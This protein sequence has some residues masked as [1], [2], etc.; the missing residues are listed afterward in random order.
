[1]QLNRIKML[2]WGICSLI[3]CW[4]L[5]AKQDAL[6]IMGTTGSPSVTTDLTAAAKDIHDGLIQRGFAPDAVEILKAQTPDDKV[7][8]DRILESLKKRQT[9]AATD[10]FWVILLGFSGRSEEGAPAFQVSGPR[11]TAANLKTALDSIPAR[12]FVLVGTSDSGS[13]VPI[14]LT[15]NRSVLAAT[16]EEGEID[17]PRFPLSWAAALKENPRAGWKEIAARA[18]ELTE[19]EY[20]DNSLA[21][22]EHARLGDPESGAI[23]E[24]PFG[25]D[26]L[27]KPAVKPEP[28]GSMALIDASDIKVEI[29]KPN[30]E[31]EKQ[32]ATAETKKL[33]ETARATPNPEG[34]A[35]ILLEQRLGYRV[36]EDRTAED[37]VMQRIYIAK[38]DGVARWANFMLP[39]DPPAVSTKLIAARI[40]QPDG[41]ST[42]FNPAKMPPATDCTSGLCGAL[43]MVFMPNAHAGCVIEI[44]YRTRHLLEASVPEF[45][46]ELPVQQ[47]IPVMQTEL[48]LQIPE[49]LGLHFK[50]R[51]SDQ[52]PV[53]NTVDGLKTLSWKLAEMPAYEALPYDPPARDIVT[54]LDVTSLGSW[55]DFAAWYRRLTS[56][57]D[58]PDPTVKAKA[59][60]LEAGATSRLDKIRKA[61]EFVS[62]LRYVAIEFGINGI[63]P[64]TPAVVLQN[65]YGDCKD[66][67]NLLVALLADMDID[68]RFCLL[69]R[70]SS[71]D[72]SFPSWQ[73]NHAIAY[74]PK[75]PAAGQPDDLWLDTTDSTAPFPTLSPGDVGRSALV[76]DKDSAQFLPVAVAGKDVTN[77]EE[78]WH[79]I[80]I[81]TGAKCWSGQVEKSWTGMADYTVRS[82]LRGLSPLQ[83]NFALA[84]EWGKQLPNSDFTEFAASPVD[85]LTQP[86]QV[87]AAVSSAYPPTPA[88]GFD[89]ASYFASRERNRSLL[90]NNGQKLHLVQT[91]D[92]P[93]APDAASLPNKSPLDLQTAGIHATIK[94]DHTGD[95]TWRRTAELTVDQPLVAQADYPGVRGMLLAW[96]GQLTH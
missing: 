6:V 92:F 74:V 91:L 44:A 31:W 58:A 33:I 27:A 72:V 45:S 2:A 42:V 3:F 23:L 62:A 9:L 69:N 67:A 32:A 94:W 29:R 34:I 70:G 12:Q 81:S 17:L 93:D 83:R 68:G 7:T 38:E 5:L 86:M 24:A 48:Q 22:S 66:K 49:K 63:R 53:E 14:L 54:A 80:T 8:V 36:G 21:E 37:F 30:A 25:V 10:E 39:Q 77:I 87:K 20:A 84:S 85:D 4:P 28:D 96:V 56:G 47:D 40:I 41:S 18:A 75:A 95:H 59:E 79:F 51:N 19:K 55:D 71:T 15:K 64:R 26:A 11:L 82:T 65:R 89:V 13:F 78:H 60:E 73:F 1:M 50:L 35:S 90:I 16:R 61:Y 46:E 76:F 52:K 43:M 88:P 57:S